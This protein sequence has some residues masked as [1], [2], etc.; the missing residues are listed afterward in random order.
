M[1][2]NV[3]ESLRDLGQENCCST[4]GCKKT[5]SKHVINDETL[6]KIKTK[7]TWIINSRKKELK[8]LAYIMRKGGLE[9]LIPTGKTE[10][11]RDWGIQFIT[12]TASVSKWMVE[13]TNRQNLLTATMHVEIENGLFNCFGIFM[14]LL[15]CS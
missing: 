4:E 3:G 13:R 10:D 5:G 11:K 7:R 9:T 12:Y 1:T 8:S 14:K 15:Y 2:V 6:K